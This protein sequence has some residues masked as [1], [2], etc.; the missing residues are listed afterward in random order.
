MNTTFN[1]Y[2]IN[3]L[4]VFKNNKMKIGLVGAGIS[5]ILMW[6]YNKYENYLKSEEERM[7]TQQNERAIMSQKFVDIRKLEKTCRDIC[8]KWT[9]SSCNETAHY[10]EFARLYAEERAIARKYI[11]PSWKSKLSCDD[12]DRINIY[13]KEFATYYTTIL[14]YDNLPLYPSIGD[15]ES[16]VTFHWVVAMTN[17]IS[18]EK[19]VLNPPFNTIPPGDSNCHKF[20]LQEIKKRDEIRG[21]RIEM[22]QNE[23]RPHFNK[24]REELFGTHAE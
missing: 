18:A 16:F 8:R 2:F 21:K 4:M 15:I 11:P 19:L 10:I 14:K 20:A 24:I 1:T 9:N 23:I 12:V 6:G 17:N 3:I 5:G 13:R 7:K 22:M